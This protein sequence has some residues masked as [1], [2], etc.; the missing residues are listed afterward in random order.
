MNNNITL[1]LLG[2][3]L[4]SGSAFAGEV[5]AP[6]QECAPCFEGSAYVG[7][8]S[9]YVFR[10]AHLGAELVDAGV[11]VSTSAWGLDLAAGA[12]YGSYTNSAGINE[13][14]INLFAELSKDLGFARL[15]TGYIWYNVDGGPDFTDDVAEVYFG[16]SKDLAYGLSTSLTYFLDASGELSSD[17]G[18]NDGY[19]QLSVSKSDIILEGLTLNNDLGYLVERGRLSYN[20]TSLSYDVSITDHAT[21]SPYLAHTWSLNGLRDEKNRFFGGV[22]LSVGF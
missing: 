3:A 5:V 14:E 13:D 7:A 2:G 17:E 22:S 1:S 11:D 21:L 4:V 10:G 16:L 6:V 12:W 8:H 15:T 19:S 20:T 18:D 9:D